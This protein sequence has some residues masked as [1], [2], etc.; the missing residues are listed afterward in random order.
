ML[1]IGLTG[2]SGAGK[3]TVAALFARYGLPVIDADQVYHDLLLPPSPCLAELVGRFGSRIVTE[4]GTLNRRA[5]AD[6]VFSDPVSLADLNH[7]SHR[8]VMREIRRQLE[9]FRREDVRAAILDAPQL[10][11]AEANRDCNIIVSV[12]ADRAIR[13]ERIVHRDGIEPDRALRRMEAQKSDAF[14]RAHSDYVI[15]NNGNP[16]LLLPA[17]ERI[18]LDVGVLEK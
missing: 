9:Q 12:L 4:Q 13:L 1:V 14:F 3:G 17:V 15:E 2:Q 10:F 11:E 8:H 6:I 7:I 16:D 5:L 18:L